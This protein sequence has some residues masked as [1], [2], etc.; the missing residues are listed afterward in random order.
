[1]P[2]DYGMDPDLLQR[3][4][5]ELA[6]PAD[7]RTD[8]VQVTGAD[9]LTEDNQGGEAVAPQ[10]PDGE[11]AVP[12]RRFKKFHDLAKEA[13]ED[14]EYWQRRALQLEQTPAPQQQNGYQIPLSSTVEPVFSGPDW[15]R[16]HAL[17]AGADE[18]AVKSA[19]RMET[20]RMAS[21]EQRAMERA[22]SA[23]E[24]RTN[25]QQEQMR[26]NVSQI[27]EGL[28]EAADILGRALTPDEEMALLDIQDEFSPKDRAGNIL[29]LMPVEKAVEIYQT[30]QTR[31]QSPRREARNAI[32]AMSSASAGG[33]T[34]GAQQP[35][36]RNSNFMPN[37]GWRANYKRVT[38]KDAPQ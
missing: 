33:D 18:E 16:F 7:Q 21:V 20:Q 9:A 24:E 23:F 5:S 2:K 26:S 25:Q 27:D 4:M 38:G 17:F 37:L 34:S 30:R 35:A 1:M 15:E 8:G 14:A 12:Y 10:S 28:E 32:A 31:T 22:I 13:Q 6:L 36:E 19:Y 11:S 3:P 29:A